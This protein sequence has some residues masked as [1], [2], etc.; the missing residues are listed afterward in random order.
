MDPDLNYIKD[1]DQTLTGSNDK[2]EISYDGKNGVRCIRIRPDAIHLAAGDRAGNIKIHDMRT[3]KE[4]YKIEAHDAEVLCLEYSKNGRLNEP[5]SSYPRLLASAS[6]DRL[7]HVFNV[8]DVSILSFNKLFILI[9]V[10]F[11]L[12]RACIH[13]DSITSVSR[14]YYFSL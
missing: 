9:L 1:Q 4:I 5:K 13:F 14:Q 6:R 2:V 12:I 8:D 7:I 3:M 10:N 11:N